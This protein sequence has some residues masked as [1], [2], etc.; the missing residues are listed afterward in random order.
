MPNRVVAPNYSVYTA[1]TVGTTVVQPF[2]A[3]SGLTHARLSFEGSA[4]RWISQ[5]GVTAHSA[6]GH[7]NSAANVV[8]LVGADLIRHATFI[9]TDTTG[10]VYTQLGTV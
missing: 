4:I 10:R 8:E 9:C 1:A 2:S 6:S 5:S 7:L 3:Y